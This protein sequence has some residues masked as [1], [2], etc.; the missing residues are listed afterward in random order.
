M[1][2]QAELL[3]RF[4][5]DGVWVFLGKGLAGTAQLGAA[6]MI[7]RIY[8]DRST[9]A[10]A[11]FLG[12]SAV[13]LMIPLVTLGYTQMLVR[14]VAPQPD[15][16]RALIRYCSQRTIAM[17]A[18]VAAAFLLFQALAPDVTSNF[19]PDQIHILTIS[20][21]IASYALMALVIEGVR[22]L[23]YV[24]LASLGLAAIRVAFVLFVGTLLALDVQ[25]S[26][27][28]V[29]GLFIAAPL[30]AGIPVILRARSTAWSAPSTPAGF[31]RASTITW[32]NQ[33]LFA[34]S[35]EVGNFVLKALGGPGDISVFA[36]TLRVVV[37][38][39]LPLTVLIGVAPRL[40]AKHYRAEGDNSAL[41]AS[42]QIFSTAAAVPMLA[43]TVLISIFGDWLLQ[44]VFGGDFS[45]AG[46]V[47]IVMSIAQAVNALFGPSQSTLNMVGLERLALVSTATG[48]VL[49]LVA[50][51]A[52]VPSL[53][54][55]GAALGYA[56]SVV[57]V[58]GMNYLWLRRSIAMFVH[59]SPSL[60]IREI[61]NRL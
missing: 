3:G 17:T 22:A 30:L 45:A 43:A 57:V 40:V 35:V 27:Q 7:T 2:N 46:G 39:Q 38:I 61:R 52:T 31:S 4:G 29:F 1:P 58:N 47:V 42:L 19:L 13:V 8:A 26:P 18:V 33:A 16:F 23:G 55:L 32:V 6:I 5:G 21:A 44:R 20:A 60:L 24:A 56:I 48:A 50:S 49:G 9:D 11:F 12:W 15:Y 53:G 54:V 25:P 36:S 59:A 28:A 10:D 14:F 51:I 37:L 41:Q 34:L